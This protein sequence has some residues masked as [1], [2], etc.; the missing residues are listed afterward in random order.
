MLNLVHRQL[1]F[2]RNR[3]ERH[4]SLTPRP[5]EDGFDQCHQADLLSE[6]VLVVV[7]DGLWRG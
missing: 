2:T 4:V 3:L 6:E 1:C 7:E 5:L